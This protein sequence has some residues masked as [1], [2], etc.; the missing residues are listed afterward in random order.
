[1]RNSTNIT[2]AS[3]ESAG[4][5]KDYKHAIAEY[6]WN[7]FDAK[8]TTVDIR[9]DSNELGFLYAITIQ[10]NGEGIAHGTLHRS[11]G[12]FLD[13]IKRTTL[14]R[15]SYTRGKKGK[16]RF[17]F[18]LFATRATWKTRYK[19]Q[20]EQVQEYEIIIDRHQ[21]ETYEDSFQ[22]A[23]PHANTGTTVVL[24]GIFGMEAAYLDSAAFRDFLAQEFGWFLFLNKD[25]N[26]QISLNGTPLPYQQFIAEHDAVTWRIA[27]DDGHAYA[28]AVHF[29]RWKENIG[30]RYYYY[31]LNTQQTEIAKE[32]TSFNNN[33]IDFHHSV[34][35]ES[36]FFNTFEQ[37]SIAIA[38]EENLFS[39]LQQHV[40]FKKLTGELRSLLERKQNK[41]VREQVAEKMLADIIDKNILP[42]YGADQQ[43]QQRKQCIMA[44]LH[45]LCVAE[46]KVFASMKADYLKAY[47]GFI[48][49]LL[50]TSKRNDILGVIEQTL[51][52]GE[53]ERA[54]IGEILMT[55]TAK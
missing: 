48:D 16:G 50:Q 6:I 29:L 11:F 55:G 32:L 9:Y 28:F 44:I 8:A 38:D 52:L 37:E 14:K 47:L 3:I 20:N 23:T 26:V 53:K 54:H 18:S 39:N 25:R 12:N 17:S 31:F 15:S 33:A 27:G 46:P 2:N 4:L 43:D 30:D 51:P 24:E 35:I 45:E 40:V 22:V 36:S 7:G 34:Y 1:M 19:D 42:S 5:P 49:L 13:S 10:D 21:K 41:F